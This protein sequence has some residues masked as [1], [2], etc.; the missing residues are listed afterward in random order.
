MYACF[1]HYITKREIHARIL[2][3]FCTATAAINPFVTEKTC[4]MSCRYVRIRDFSPER[5][6]TYGRNP[7]WQTKEIGE[8]NS[9][10]LLLSVLAGSCNTYTLG[11]RVHGAF[12]VL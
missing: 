1:Y 4:N 11:P 12:H 2:N 6:K 7:L 9:I 8:H 10:M 3:W 5:L